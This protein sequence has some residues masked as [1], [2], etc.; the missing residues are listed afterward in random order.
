MFGK[1]FCLYLM[2]LIFVIT[3]MLFACLSGMNDE[4]LNLGN[5]INL[6]LCALIN[7][8]TLYHIC[9]YAHYFANIVRY[10]N[11]LFEHIYIYMCVCVC[12]C[13]WCFP[14]RYH[15]PC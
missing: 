10:K 14:L 12:V 8:T 6:G 13:V 1:V 3:V 11:I 7:S 2:L 9:N 15:L 4:A 5:K